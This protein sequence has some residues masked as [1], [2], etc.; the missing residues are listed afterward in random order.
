[1][2]ELPAT[3]S[4]SLLVGESEAIS[5]QQEHPRGRDGRGGIEAYFTFT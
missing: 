2:A 4:V 1:M 5:V 3:G